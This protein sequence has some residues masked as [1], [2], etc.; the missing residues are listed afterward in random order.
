MA[1]NIEVTLTLNS[2]QFDR[3]IK[4]AQA[5]LGRVKGSVGGVGG[6]FG[7]L[8][9]KLAIAGTAFLGIKKAL[10]GITGS[11]GA[12]QQIQDIGVVLK[13]VVGSAEGGALALQQVRDIAQE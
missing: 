10:D 9:S 3:G 4:S 2:R 12:A 1:K 11:V 6:A 5:S 8:A 7:G 13:N